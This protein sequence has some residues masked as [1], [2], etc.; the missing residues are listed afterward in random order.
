MELNKKIIDEFIIRSS[1]T[2]LL[3][4]Y[5]CKLMFDKK[6]A[7]N[8]SELENIRSGEY[9]YGFFIACYAFD[10][11]GFTIN[12]DIIN[13]TRYNEVLSQAIYDRLVA[14]ADDHDKRIPEGKWR[15]DIARVAT[16][17]GVSTFS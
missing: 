14:T 2:G 9:P 10:F 4:L 15:E 16:L 3:T 6:A 7:F 8:K 11:F 5:Y 17:A 13:I 12:S 1:F